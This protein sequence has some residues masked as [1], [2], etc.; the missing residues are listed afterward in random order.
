MSADAIAPPPIFLNGPF[1]TEFDFDDAAAIPQLGIE[2]KGKVNRQLITQEK[3]GSTSFSATT[4][5]VQYGK[6][7]GSPACLVAIDFIFRFKPK[8]LARYSYASITV[9]FRRATDLGNHRASKAPPQDDPHVANMA[10][11]SMY[12]VAAAFEERPAHD[13]TVPV[14]F[15][16]PLGLGTAVESHAKIEDTG[17]TEHRME[18][19][20]QPF[21]DDD[22]IDAPNG[23]SWDLF[24]DPVKKDGILRNFRAAVVVLNPPGQPMWMKVVVVP[25]VKFSVDP[26]RLFG[27]NDPFAKLLQL[28]DQPV[29][30]D[31][32][33]PKESQVDFGC[34]D[35]TSPHFPWANILVHTGNPTTLKA[36]ATNP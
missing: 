23:A 13:V 8:V 35:F 14:V 36:E 20:G 28:N 6:Y 1:E 10:P 2:A 27:K 26:R 9:T 11:K 17:N 19:H 3:I 22:H 4:Q 7:H 32:K 30:L 29:P 15:E 24:E 33:T 12:G 18:I 34:D 25:S 16:N 5:H 21:E 31:G